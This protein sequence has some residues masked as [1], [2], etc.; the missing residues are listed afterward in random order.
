MSIKLH[1]DKHDNVSQMDQQV[2]VEAQTM[3]VDL[4]HLVVFMKNQDLMGMDEGGLADHLLLEDP[5]TN[6]DPGQE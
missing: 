3:V 6:L 1:L 5:E 4:V 2:V